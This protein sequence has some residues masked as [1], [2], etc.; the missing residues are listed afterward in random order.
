MEVVSIKEGENSN[1]TAQE[2][3]IE[4]YRVGKGR[5]VLGD[6]CFGSLLRSQ[7]LERAWVEVTDWDESAKVEPGE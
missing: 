1:S 6:Y 2:K 3:V 7:R 5:C 4:I